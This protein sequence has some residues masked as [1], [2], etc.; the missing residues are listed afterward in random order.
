MDFTPSKLLGGLA[1]LRPGCIPTDC[2]NKKSNPCV[3]GNAIR[4]ETQTRVLD[5]DFCP[6]YVNIQTVCVAPSIEVSRPHKTAT[7]GMLQCGGEHTSRR[8]PSPSQRFAIIWT[9]RPTGHSLKRPV[10]HQN[11]NKVSVTPRKYLL[12]VIATF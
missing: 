8:Q 10:T 6:T 4:N 9:S 12:T 2:A 7:R 3:L 11:K 1:Y 5:L